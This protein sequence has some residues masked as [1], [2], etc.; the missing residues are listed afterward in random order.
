MVADF[1]YDYQNR[2]IQVSTDSGKAHTVYTYDEGSSSRSPSKVQIPTGGTFVFNR[3]ELGELEYVMTPR[4]HIHGFSSQYSLGV[5]RF[6][7]VSPWNRNPYEMH[8]DH[9]G[10]LVAKVRIN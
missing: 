9:S 1:K 4:G 8:Y 5:H 10:R 3:N 6:S 2:L 7:Y